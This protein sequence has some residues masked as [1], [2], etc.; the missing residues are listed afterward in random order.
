MESVGKPTS[1]RQTVRDFDEARDDV[2]AVALVSAG[3]YASHLQFVFR[4]I[5]ASAPI[6]QFATGWLLV[7]PP[8]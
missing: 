8:N 4:E 3:T 2:V 6:S 5:T 1:K 7:L